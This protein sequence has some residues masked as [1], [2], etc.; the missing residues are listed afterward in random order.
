MFLLGAG[1]RE[2]RGCVLQAENSHIYAS[3]ECQTH[4]LDWR[5]HPFV[6]PGG[7]SDAHVFLCTTQQLSSEAVIEFMLASR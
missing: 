7:G 5:M 4:A 2:P 3:T 6:A 1:I